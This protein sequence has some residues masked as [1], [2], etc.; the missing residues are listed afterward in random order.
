[1]TKLSQYKVVDRGRE[2]FQLISR[3]NKEF[4]SATDVQGPS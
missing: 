2:G 4:V 1:M 3:L